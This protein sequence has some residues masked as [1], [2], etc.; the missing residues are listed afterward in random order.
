MAP[1]GTKEKLAEIH[2]AAGNIATDE[3]RVHVFEGTWG[4][5]ASGENAI[6]K[7]GG[8]ALDLGFQDWQHV[9]GGAVGDMAVGPGDVLPSRCT[10]GIEQAR[11]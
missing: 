7:T 4:E 8:E 6:A 1:S 10:R 11:L 3:V 5:N 2:G 9:H